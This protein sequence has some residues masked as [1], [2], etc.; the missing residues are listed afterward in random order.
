MQPYLVLIS[1]LFI[2]PVSA[3][4]RHWTVTADDW[5][6][7]RDGARVVSLAP[8]SNAVRAWSKHPDDHLAIHYPGGEEGILWSQELRDWL[9]SL[10]VPSDR[11]DTVPGLA[12]SDAVS[13][14]LR[15]REELSP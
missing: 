14:V 1:L 13:I 7:P 12:R 4:E 11:V 5:Y 2:A 8:L 6:L 9:V 3:A 15:N 10:G